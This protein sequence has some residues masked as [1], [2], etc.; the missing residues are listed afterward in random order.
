MKPNL[1][2]KLI[3]ASSNKA[4][5]INEVTV[6]H[7]FH[8]VAW[9]ISIF[10]FSLW[11][12][13][14][15][16][17]NELTPTLSFMWV[18]WA[19]ATLIPVTLTVA[20]SKDKQILPTRTRIEYIVV[21]L[22]RLGGVYV[23]V[24]VGQFFVIFFLVVINGFSYQLVGRPIQAEFTVRFVFW[25]VALFFC[26]FFAL[27]G[28]AHTHVLNR[29]SLHKFALAHGWKKWKSLVDTL[30]WGLG[31]PFVA[32]PAVFI[33][34]L[35]L[36]N[37]G[38]THRSLGLIV[39]LVFAIALAITF[40]RDH[41]FRAKT[42]SKNTIQLFH[43]NTNTLE[44]HLFSLTEVAQTLHFKI[45]CTGFPTSL[46]TLLNQNE[47]DEYLR[48]W[49]IENQS[50]SET[51]R[52]GT[53]LGNALFPEALKVHINE[54]LQHAQA[55]NRLLRLGIY[56]E[57]KLAALPWECAVL[58]LG[59][60]EATRNDLLINHTDIKLARL[61]DLDYKATQQPAPIDELNTT[62]RVVLSFANPID[63]T[64]LPR[65][66]EEMK[67]LRNLFSDTSLLQGNM[68][69]HL[70]L[71]KLASMPQASIFHFS[72]HGALV[73]TYDYDMQASWKC[74]LKIEDIE[75][76]GVD[77]DPYDLSLFLKSSAQIVVLNA[78]DSASSEDTGN[79]HNIATGLIRNGIT[80]VV[81]MQYK[82]RDSSAV[83]F[84]QYFYRQLIVGDDI[85]EALAFT[86]LQIVHK[87]GDF[88]GAIAPVIYITK[89][90]I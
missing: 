41:Q 70:T 16:P 59:K 83:A 32:Y 15:E 21:L 17:G 14:A 75:Q 85:E 86:R 76:S 46:Q 87:Q 67:M 49:V 56:A 47:L 12:A 25:I 60:G 52:F 33:L 28:I 90:L 84:S 20:T 39:A 42:K 29:L 62:P 61:V 36:A 1:L 71:Q 23:G 38:Q 81:A 2:E 50:W 27:L 30:I 22:N 66:N 72:G 57:G 9:L 8:G 35:M 18:I 77:I 80:C 34:W 55:H 63:T 89:A 58:K 64:P 10:F 44:I 7:F 4:G 24:L 48:N 68:I 53:L 11:L 69:E 5:S 26:S 37:W 40:S 78:C 6:S 19:A 13:N 74:V 3:I 31:I 43:Q 73:K 54:N 45:A 65:L 79:W 88:S 82:I 51:M